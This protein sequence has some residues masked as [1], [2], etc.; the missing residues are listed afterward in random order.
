VPQ[1]RVVTPVQQADTLLNGSPT[2]LRKGN[3]ELDHVGGLRVAQLGVVALVGIDT[4]NIHWEEDVRAADLLR[5]LDD[6]DTGNDVH[7]VLL[8]EVLCNGDLLALDVGDTR[9]AVIRVGERALVGILLPD[10]VDDVLNRRR[11]VGSGDVNFLE[12]AEVLAEEGLLP[13]LLG[14]LEAR[15]ELRRRA[16]EDLADSLQMLA[17]LSE[18]KS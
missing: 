2:L 7:V 8:L 12:G 11:Y 3:S 15:S 17:M 1:V 5:H 13:F 18:D 16:V 14:F 9:A 6:W 4:E 10:L